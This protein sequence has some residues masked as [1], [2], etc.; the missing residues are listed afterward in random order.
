MIKTLYVLKHC[1]LELYL[2]SVV[3]NK[4]TKIK[5]QAF[6]YTTSGDAETMKNRYACQPTIWQVV[7]VQYDTLKGETV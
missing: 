7:P 3:T 5:N 1:H 2:A 6:R 4:M